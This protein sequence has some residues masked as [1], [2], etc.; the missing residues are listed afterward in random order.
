M[1]V[2]IDSGYAVHQRLSIDTSTNA[3]NNTEY[4]MTFPD[5]VPLLSPGQEIRISAWVADA[6]D[7]GENE[8][9]GKGYIFKNTLRY[10]DGTTVSDGT[11]QTLEEKLV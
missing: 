1:S 8:D 4:K 5:M 9:G 7:Q 10:T 11:L 2:P 3:Q 6:W